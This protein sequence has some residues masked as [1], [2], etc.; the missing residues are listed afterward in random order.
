MDKTSQ[1]IQAELIKTYIKPTLRSR[2]YQASGRTWWKV[3]GDFFIV[4]NL[5][6]SQWSNKEKLSF[7]LNIGVGLTLML[8]EKGK[9]RPTHFDAITYLRQNAFLS[10]ERLEHHKRCGGGL[11]YVIARTTNLDDFVSDFKIDLEGCILERLDTLR[12][13]QDC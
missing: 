13:L 12:T 2:G 8:V 3:L 6:T 4:I 7:C 1:E 10:P 11:G 9:Q 5:Q